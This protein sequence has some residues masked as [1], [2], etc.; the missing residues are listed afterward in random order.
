MLEILIGIGRLPNRLL[1]Y[2][3]AGGG[4]LTRHLGAGFVAL[5]VVL[6]ASSPRRMS[7]VSHRGV[8]PDSPAVAS[9]TGR[10]GSGDALFERNRPVIQQRQCQETERHQHHEEEKE[11][12][13]AETRSWGKKYKSQLFD[14]CA[15][16]FIHFFPRSF[17][18]LKTSFFQ[19][20]RYNLK[21]RSPPLES[22]THSAGLMYLFTSHSWI[23][24]SLIGSWSKLELINYRK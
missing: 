7:S 12:F 15:F 22:R 13:H 16:D 1:G 19:F 17:F 4:H 21:T 3:G 23:C 5:L 6:A 2:D 24:K 8:G 10:G 18:F 11:L 9:A 20:R 14:N